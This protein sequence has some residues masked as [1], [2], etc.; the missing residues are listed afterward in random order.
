MVI[1]SGVPAFPRGTIPR[2]RS[3]FVFVSIPPTT[4]SD[5]M[6]S[7]EDAISAALDRIEG[8]QRLNAFISIAPREIAMAQARQL[9][10]ECRVGSIRSPLH[11]MPISI[12]VSWCSYH[13]ITLLMV[14]GC[15]RHRSGTRSADDGGLQRF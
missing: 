13:F 7:S 1:G 9:D 2:L 10:E 3:S 11:G 15:D 6:H 8:M 5:A 4:A 12:K 14:S